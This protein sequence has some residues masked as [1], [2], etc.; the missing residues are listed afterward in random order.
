[1]HIKVID[2]LAEV[3]AQAWNNLNQNRYPFLRH[4]FLRG[5]E[6]NDC[7]GERTGWYPQHLLAYADDGRL[8]GAM[9]L[10]LK[11][12]SF[13]EFVFDWSWADAYHRHGIEYYPK[14][15]CAIPF[16]PATGPR[17]L[18]LP[19][20]EHEAITGHLIKTALRLARE[21]QCS[22]LHCLFPTERDLALLNRQGLVTRVGCQ[23]HWHNQQYSCFA[24]FLS[25]LN[26][27]RRKNIRR[28]R[29]LIQEA[30]IE[31]AVISGDQASEADWVALHDFYA[32]TFFERGRR[33]PLT[34]AFFL[35][36]AASMGEQIVLVFAYKKVG[37]P[38]AGALS[39]SSATT[40]YG[41]HWGSLAEFDS[42]H[43]EVCYYQNIEYCI[44]KG[45]QC[46]E[47]GA[48]GEHKIW[49]GFLPTLTYSAHWIAHPSFDAAI[50]DFLRRETP[51]VQQ[52]AQQ[53]QAHSPYRQSR[54]NT[55][56]E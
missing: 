49:R 3:P 7:L 8:I 38:V 51:A 39:F 4:E 10:Y 21:Q 9:P 32:N 42:L 11:D 41:R 13:G 55:V 28:E 19:G 54:S 25:K 17:L 43:F 36:I 47:P 15:V 23:Y 2:R 37:K 5:L 56:S 18:S 27:K 22:S 6:R 34:L 1:M 53:L 26:S 14:L 40:L 31:L 52:Y 48:Q 12:N 33:P 24:D 29:R 35:D 16:T 45:I 46:F 44:A 50:K 20:T 30:D